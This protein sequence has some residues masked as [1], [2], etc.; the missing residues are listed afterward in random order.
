VTQL[1]SALVLAIEVYTALGILFALVFVFAGLATVDPAAKGA[2]LGFR[3]LI[4]PAS[5]ALW[6]WLALR[7]LRS[8]SNAGAQPREER[9]AHRRLARDPG[10]RA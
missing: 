3:L 10:D 1:A 8:L 7:W 9:T 4:L 6:P 2:P 5:A